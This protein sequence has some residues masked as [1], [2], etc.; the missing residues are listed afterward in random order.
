MDQYGNVSYGSSENNQ[1]WIS[2]PSQGWGSANDFA[3]DLVDGGLAVERGGDNGGG[4]GGGGCFLTTAIVEMR[5]EAD[6]GETLNILRKFRDNFL[7]QNYPNEIEEYYR[8]APQLVSAIPKTNLVWG[9][10][11]EQIDLSISYINRQ[12]N[13]NAYSTYK[14]MVKVLENDWLIK[15]EL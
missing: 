12:E 5:G 4:G 8:I 15:K 6:N 2:G 3:D 7:L 10:I 9:W 11:G 1:G 13:E 14:N